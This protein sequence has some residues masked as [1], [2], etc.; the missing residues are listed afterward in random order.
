VHSVLLGRTRD[1]NLLFYGVTTAGR[2]VLRP[3]APFKGACSRVACECRSG[4]QFRCEGSATKNGTGLNVGSSRLIRLMITI[5]R[6]I[7]TH[8]LKNPCSA[9]GNE[10]RHERLLL[11]ATRSALT[12]HVVRYSQRVKISRTL[13]QSF[14]WSKHLRELR[15]L[16]VG[17]RVAFALILVEPLLIL[18]SLRNNEAAIPT[19]VEP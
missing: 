4:I 13:L 3:A 16:P 1:P 15:R 8:S 18:C 19:N 2:P 14:R 10:Q 17:K 12:R 11:K 6:N 9:R 7:R 5:S